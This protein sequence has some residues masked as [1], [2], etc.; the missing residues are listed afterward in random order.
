MSG[1]WR[2]AVFPKALLAGET[3][4]GVAGRVEIYSRRDPRRSTEVV[5]IIATSCSRLVHANVRLIFHATD[6]R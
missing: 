5:P 6:D 4:S 1:C 3:V 2:F